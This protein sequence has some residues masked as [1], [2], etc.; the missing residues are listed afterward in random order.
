MPK[1]SKREAQ[2]RTVTFSGAA[3]HVPT[4]IVQMIQK[5]KASEVEFFMTP[6]LQFHSKEKNEAFITKACM[7]IEGNVYFV[8]QKIGSTSFTIGY[9]KKQP[10]IETERKIAKLT[11]EKGCF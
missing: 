4:D 3:V 11:S 7:T 9:T 1:K 10:E 6:E 5:N 2:S 8:T